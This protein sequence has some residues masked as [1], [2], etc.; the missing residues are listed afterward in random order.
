MSEIYGRRI[1]LSC[2]NWFLVL[3]HIGCALAPNIETLIICRMFAGIGGAG[4]ITLGAGLIADLF[5]IE[6]RGLAT[7]MWSCGPLIGPV[8][9]PIAGG[10]MGETIGWRWIFW[11]V[12]IAAGVVSFGIEILYRETYAAVLIR[13]KTE[14]LSKELGRSDL[15]SAYEPTTKQVSLSSVMKQDLKRPILLLIRSPIILLLS[16]YVAVI[17]GLLYLFFT[18]IATVFITQYGFSAGLSGL[19]FL[20]IG[21]GYFIGL[22]LYGLTNDRIVMKLVQ[23]NGGKYEPEMRLPAMIVFASLLPISFFWYGWSVDKNVHWIVP[24]IGMLPYGIGLM[25][26]FLPVQTYI[27][28]SYQEYAASANASL[29]TV[30]SLVG[31]VLPLAG[32]Q[33]FKA[34]GLGW[35]NSLLGFIALA[36]LPVPIIFSRYGQRIREKFRVSLDGRNS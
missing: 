24:I 36:F 7:A 15:R 27:I 35:G 30:R 31:A 6:Q 13:R 25:G 22:A 33:L 1:V 21:L 18:T 32:P 12:M 11:V 28:D 19:A 34:L 9:G 14:R 3:W 20:G 16:L 10:F 29:T 26:V 4:C 17:Y 5:P 23:R 8:V 2:A